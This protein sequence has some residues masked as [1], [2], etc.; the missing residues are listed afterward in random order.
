ML[1]IYMSGLMV[2]KA[3]AQPDLGFPDSFAGYT[4]SDDPQ[5]GLKD[6]VANIVK[7]VLGFIGILTILIILWGGFKWMTSAGNEDKIGE[8][9]KIISAGVIGL[10]IIIMAYFIAE[11]V[12]SQLEGAVQPA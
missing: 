12:I 4:G 3:A 9:K 7:I 11:F 10:V 1:P 6:T 8:A 2:K 5:Q